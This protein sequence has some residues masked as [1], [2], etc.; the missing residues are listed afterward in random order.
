MNIAIQRSR[1]DNSALRQQLQ[2]R[3]HHH[4]ISGALGA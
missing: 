1:Q 3:Q 2:S 4:L